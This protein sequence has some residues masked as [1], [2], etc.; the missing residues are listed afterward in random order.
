[1]PERQWLSGREMPFE[2]RLGMILV[3]VCPRAPH[4]GIV[5]SADRHARKGCQRTCRPRGRAFCTAD[6]WGPSGP[7]ARA[8]CRRLAPVRSRASAG[9]RAVAP[10]RDAAPSSAARAARA[11][12]L[13]VACVR[14][15]RGG[16][17]PGA[18]RGPPRPGASGSRASPAAERPVRP[19]LARAGLRLASWPLQVTFLEP[20]L[21]VASGCWCTFP[22][23]S[24][25]QRRGDPRDLG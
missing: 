22:K 2:L 8:A 19:G 16:P 17:C 23:A 21:C 11:C 15:G 25:S 9:D 4:A 1:M 12:A 18:D 3:S 6:R 24:L 13:V 7:F 5:L 10:C 20:G 14:R